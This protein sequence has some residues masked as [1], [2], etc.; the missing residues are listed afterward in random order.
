MSTRFEKKI[1]MPN[2]TMGRTTLMD[3]SDDD[4]KSVERWHKKEWDEFREEVV[5]YKTKVLEAARSAYNWNREHCI[6]CSKMRKF[7]SKFRQR[8]SIILGA[9]GAVKHA[10]SDPG[11]CTFTAST[12][13]NLFDL[14]FEPGAAYTRARLAGDGDWYSNTGSTS[15]GSS[16]GTWQ[17]S[18]AIGDYDTQWNRISGDV[19]NSGVAGSDGGWTGGATTVAVGYAETTGGDSLGGSFSLVCRDGTTFITLFTDSFLMDVEVEAKN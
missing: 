16:D 9:A 2:G 11:N 10:S 1:I 18:C 12:I 6:A 4:L 15:W 5:A 14:D 7:K 3:L 13:S 8:G 19:P 17:G